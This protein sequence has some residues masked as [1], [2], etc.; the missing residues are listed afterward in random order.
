MITVF[1]GRL[2]LDEDV[3][4]GEYNNL[5]PGDASIH[6]ES[7]VRCGQFVSIIATNYALGKDGTPIWDTPAAK[8]GVCIGEGCWLA[9]GCVILP[10]VELGPGCT[11][12]ANAVV[13]KSF[14]AG[15]RLGG[16]PARPF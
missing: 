10:G 12:G 7:H 2:V 15:T 4:I 13:T 14:P 16:V 11:V 5:R 3:H 6:I 9:T 1:G 8:Q